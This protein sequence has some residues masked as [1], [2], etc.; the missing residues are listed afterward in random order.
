MLHLEMMK[1]WQSVAM[2]N[3]QEGAT[4]LL[5]PLFQF[6]EEQKRSENMAKDYESYEEWVKK[7]H[8]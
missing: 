2:L 6:W 1:D 8:L 3:L 7:I 5:T 4:N